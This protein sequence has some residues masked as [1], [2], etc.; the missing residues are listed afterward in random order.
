VHAA[1]VKRRGFV[2]HTQGLSVRVVGTTFSVSTTRDGV[3]VAVSEGRVLVEPPRGET[4]VV[5]PGQRVRFDTQKWK[6]SQ[7]A[8]SSSQ[9]QE[10][11]E[12]LAVAPVEPAGSS[13]P[14]SAALVVPERPVPS[15]PARV[16]VSV[17][18]AVDG[19]VTPK[20]Q[21]LAAAPQAST[22]LH[23]A[24]ALQAPPAAPQVTLEVEPPPALAAPEP[25]PP[26]TEEAA[27]A[28]FDWNA[29]PGSR[30]ALPPVA[31]TPAAMVAPPQKAAADL[32]EDLELLFLQRAQKAYEGGQCERYLLGLEELASDPRPS[33]GRAEQARVLRARCF[34]ALGRTDKA[35]EE[36]RRYLRDYAGGRY[37]GEAARELNRL[38][39]V[40]YP[41]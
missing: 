29:M 34:D 19:V 8:L 5:E 15:K 10:L 11:S 14:L 24:P 6:P 21:V 33:A 22:R 27:Q 9:Q 2:V 16:K 35:Q 36:Y 40:D 23:E 39:F 31:V 12:V 28:G 13:A 4:M 25:P 38:D 3:E 1:H 20:V 17:P 26:P 41:R 18:A 7:G 30:Q 37:A 32:P